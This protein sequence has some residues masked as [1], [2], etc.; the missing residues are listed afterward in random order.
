M[1]KSSNDKTRKARFESLENRNLM[2]GNVTAALVGGELSLTGDN[3]SNYLVVHQTGANRFQVQGINTNIKF[4]SQ[5][6]RSITFSS[7]IDI[8]FNMR[9]GNDSVTVYNSSLAGSMGVD[10]GT[11]NDVLALPTSVLTTLASI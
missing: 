10:M 9:G 2:A 6:A 7:V 1:H 5:T 8:G 3:S 11:G 4:G